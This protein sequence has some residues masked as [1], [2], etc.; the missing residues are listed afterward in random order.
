MKSPFLLDA[1]LINIAVA[2]TNVL[3]RS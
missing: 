1:L 3:V 2:C